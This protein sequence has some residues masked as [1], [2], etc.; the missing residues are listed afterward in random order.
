MKPAASSCAVVKFM[1][2]QAR[3]AVAL[4]AALSPW[5]L[6]TGCGWG[7]YRL[8]HATVIIQNAGAGPIDIRAIVSTPTGKSG[9]AFS[10]QRLEPGE[11]L[12]TDMVDTNYEDFRAGEYVVFASCRTGGEFMVRGHPAMA[13]RL[14]PADK[15]RVKVSLRLCGD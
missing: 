7:S 8:N 15:R 12:E 6:S 5:P 2:R 4:V 3:A 10:R 13:T 14:G 9:F 1:L 11:S